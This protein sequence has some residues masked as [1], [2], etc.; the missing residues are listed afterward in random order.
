MLSIT[1]FRTTM[2]TGMELRQ[3]LPRAQMNIEDA[4]EKIRPLMQEV[5]ARGAVALRELSEKFDGV[6]PEHLRV[7]EE[8]LSSALEQLDSA[9]REAMDISIAHNRAG[10]RAQVPSERVT[11]IMP[12]GIVKQRWIPVERVGLYVPG[13]LAV[14]PSSVIMNVVAAQEAGVGQIAVASPPQTRFGGRVHPTILAACQLLGVKEVYAVG[15]AQA[16]AMFA[17]GA[18]GEAG[19]DPDPLCQP[20]D[21][22]TGPGNIY[23][24][25]AK[26]L[27]RAVCGIDAEAGPTEIGIIADKSANPALVAADM[28]SQAEHDPNA[29]SVLFTD[30][31]ELARKV[32]A[33]IV[34]AAQAT[35]HSQRVCQALS[36]PQSGIVLVADIASAIDAVNAYAP[37]HLEIHT[38]EAGE[39]ANQIRN[40][41]AIFVGPYTP[42]PLG[43]YLAG[44]NHVLPTGGTGRY[45]GGLSVMAYLKPVQQIEYQRGA[46]EKMARPLTAFADAEDLPA[47]E[48]AVNCRFE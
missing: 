22:I 23:V 12:G 38:V 25:A 4:A 13:G 47:H 20:V 46:L 44:S 14:Y 5:K 27:V 7:P 2:P 29:A 45:E 34:P 3:A 17:Y 28:I 24:A 8:E 32:E 43:D 42:V 10:H 36:G 18:S 15:G 6:R 30:S 26:R 19:I 1:D 31:E 39:V 9:V 16:I 21:V 33:E 40:A 37:E 11:E 41:G 35:K 48:E